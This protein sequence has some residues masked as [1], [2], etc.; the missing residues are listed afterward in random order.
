MNSIAAVTFAFSWNESMQA[1]AKSGRRISTG[2]FEVDLT[3]HK[4]LR[5]GQRVPLQEQPFRVLALLLEHP[6]QIIPREEIQ[7]RLWPADTY[8]SFDEGVNTAIRKLRVLF[9]DSADNPRFI[10]TIPRHGYRFIAPVTELRENGSAQPS[11]GNLDSSSTETVPSTRSSR[12]TA[13]LIAAAILL[14][15]AAAIWFS[16]PRAPTVTNAVRIMEKRKTC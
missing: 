1:P 12:R 3:T 7:S 8:V 15:I 4:V 11:T 2:L 5:Q 13:L 14:L 6:G 10:E 9:G 16:Q